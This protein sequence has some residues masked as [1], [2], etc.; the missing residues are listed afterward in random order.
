MQNATEKRS[1]LFLHTLLNRYAM[2]VQY[3]DIKEMISYDYY[4]E[5][6]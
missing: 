2:K 6:S 3:G 4:F 5:G 1:S